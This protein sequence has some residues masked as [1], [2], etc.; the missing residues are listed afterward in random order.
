[1]LIHCIVY[2]LEM[3]FKLLLKFFKGTNWFILEV[4]KYGDLNTVLQ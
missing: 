2:I 4:I 3:L 1:M